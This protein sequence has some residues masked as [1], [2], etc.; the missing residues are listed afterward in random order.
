MIELLSYNIFLSR[1]EKRG[2][3]RPDIE[4]STVHALGSYLLH[5]LTQTSWALFWKG[6][7]NVSENT[8]LGLS[9]LI[10]FRFSPSMGSVINVWSAA[11]AH[12]DIFF[13]KSLLVAIVP[14]WNKKVIIKTIVHTY[15]LLLN[16]WTFW[17]PVYV[18]VF[19]KSLNIYFDEK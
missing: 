10:K 17:K 6:V 9:L 13:F 18:F 14:N 16:V 19:F 11:N 8:T 5:Y 7:G 2:V 4:K 15:I 3:F 12:S 1:I